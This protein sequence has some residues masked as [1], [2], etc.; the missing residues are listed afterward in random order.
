M[1]L[2]II[3]Y[4]THDLDNG[5][6]I[7]LI[8]SE[9]TYS[10]TI[11]A[12]IRSGYA[13]ENDTNQGL[14]HFL[15]HISLAATKKW[16]TKKEFTQITEFKGG[17]SNGSTSNETLHY[18]INVPYTEVE[19]GV[20][21]IHQV[22]Y[23]ATINPKYLE[24]ERTIILDEITKNDDDVYYKC[25]KYVN[26]NL[27]VHKSGYINDPAG[28]RES[29]KS[30]TRKDIL[31]HYKFAHDPSKVVICVTGNFDPKKMLAQLKKYFGKEKSVNKP[32]EFPEDETKTSQILVQEDHKTDLVLANHIYKFLGG[33]DVTTR[34]YHEIG[35]LSV[36]LS[37]PMGSRLMQRLR[38]EEGLLYSINSR[39]MLCETF[40]VMNI[41]YECPPEIYAKVLPIVNEEMLKLYEKGVNDKELDHFKTHVVNRNLVYYDN[42]H[43]I[44]RLIRGPFF[45]GNEIMMLEDINKYIKG[46]SKKTLNDLVRK[47]LVPN[48][49][50]IAAYGN[51]NPKV[52]GVIEKSLKK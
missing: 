24:Q 31:D 19:F 3:K 27:S 42:I 51:V 28:T 38:E 29:V 8:P 4:K 16:P 18:Y 22:L 36:I 13:L 12:L 33:K 49:V 30:F 48:E 35:L 44:S 17:S 34:D 26:K 20:D 9:S 1:P 14:T 21:F 45:W 2:M 25:F 41:S 23:Q 43:A 37:G 10:V 39:L 32:L 5:L 46:I 15:E 52:Q 47:H 11:E 40:G 7:L 6:K 50:N